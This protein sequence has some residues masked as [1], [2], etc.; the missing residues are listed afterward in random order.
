MKK[1][2]YLLIFFFTVCSALLFVLLCKVQ[3]SM[4]DSMKKSFI[5]QQTKICQLSLE[6]L[7]QLFINFNQN[8]EY[9]L[10]ELSPKKV[11][12]CKA[13]FKNQ[14]A[15]WHL[16]KSNQK[17]WVHIY[18]ND[19]KE[20][21]HFAMDDVYQKYLSP[22]QVG[23]TGVTWV[24]DEK[25]RILIDDKPDFIGKNI[26]KVFNN[27]EYSTFQDFRQH[28]ITHPTQGH[29]T[30]MWPSEKGVRSRIV[31]YVSTEILGIKLLICNSFDFLEITK[32]LQKQNQNLM[33]LFIC[34][35][36]LFTLMML[37]VYYYLL[38]RQSTEKQKQHLSKFLSPKVVDAV[39]H[40]AKKGS[41]LQIEVKDVS[42]FFIDI[43]DFTCISEKLGTL[44]VSRFLKEFYELCSE[45]IFIHEGIVDKYLGDSVM[46]I[47][48]APLDLRDHANAAVNCSQSLLEKFKSFKK[49][50]EAELEGAKV[51][52]GIAIASGEVMTGPIGSKDKFD[53]TAIGNVVNLASRIEGLNK[54]YNTQM[55]ISKETFK[56]INSSKHFKSYG[57]QKIRGVQD[58]KE[59]YF[60]QNNS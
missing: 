4:V 40:N 21:I 26:F 7:N 24:M 46:A 19:K 22:L 18:H 53:Y 23:A 32:A 31:S 51:E 45:E 47:F 38:E 58:N 2:I 35:F 34:G 6:R 9:L 12:H 56:R 49:N 16:C 44:R 11:S 13:V 15:S 17:F 59:I 37:V 14:N 43:R 36:S 25:G 55:A 30:Y 8:K 57:Q 28:L 29:Y 39:M 20:P 50:W 1:L 42:V 5:D 52:V 41:E 48:G 60:L 27:Q 54:R 33:I 10:N 3:D